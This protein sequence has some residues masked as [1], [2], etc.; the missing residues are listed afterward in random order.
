MRKGLI[1]FGI[2]AAIVFIIYSWGSGIY[3]SAVTLEQDVKESGIDDIVIKPFIP[4]ELFRKVHYYI[5][6]K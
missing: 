1:T 3:N 4:D 6:K 5:F 2:I